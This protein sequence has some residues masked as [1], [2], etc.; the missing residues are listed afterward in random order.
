MRFVSLCVVLLLLTGCSPS[1][2]DEAAQ[3]GEANAAEAGEQPGETV[4][5]RR[6]LEAASIVDATS[7]SPSESSVAASRAL[8][9]TAPSVV[10]APAGDRSA[11][12]EAA[13]A[14]TQ[15]GVPLLLL[16]E[17]G[18]S[19]SSP[20]DAASTSSGADDGT[21]AAFEEIERLEAQHVLMVGADTATT[22]SSALDV[23]VASSR[24]DLPTL[25]K[26]DGLSDVSV[27]VL[28]GDE[29][30]PATTAATRAT[31]EAAGARVLST[32]DADI[33]VDPDVVTALAEASPE[34]VVGLSTQF[35]PAEQLA[36]RAE[37]A[38]TGVQLPGGGQALFP[39]RR[40]IALYG[41]PGTASLGVLGEQDLDESV[42]R[43]KE[44][45]VEYEPFSDVPTVPT[46]E[47][48]ATIAQG[49]AGADGD[50]SGEISTEQLRPWVE[51]AG[52]EGVYVVLDL[53]PG[54][55]NF[56]DQAKIYEELLRMPHVGLALDPEWRLAPG[57]EPLGQIGHVEA[58]EVNSVI[59]WL[60]DLTAQENLPQKLLVL[61]Q[62]RVSML[63]DSQTYDLGLR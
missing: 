28:D 20:D 37:L 21:E 39:G 25:E 45:A 19:G 29:A 56:L 55:A 57:E 6:S 27:L 38:K 4:E 62:F 31:A 52:E 48:I 42:Q 26:V 8:F 35:G 34:H 32:T 3:D 10:L 22:L 5:L 2:P 44:V 15:T 46:M 49:D 40:L 16:D 60:A 12:D 7:G 17:A 47:I 36:S 58:D 11:V 1:G 53:Q 54:R 14:A 50:Y 24:D 41:T 63:P 9:V 18:P 23:D 43:A 51:Q 61:H 13:Q 30:A 59:T 33:R